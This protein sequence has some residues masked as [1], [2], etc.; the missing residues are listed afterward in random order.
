MAGKDAAKLPFANDGSFLE[1]FM[2]ARR[3]RRKRR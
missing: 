3:K 2:K 1:Q